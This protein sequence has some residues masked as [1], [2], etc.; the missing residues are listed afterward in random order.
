MLETLAKVGYAGIVIN[1]DGYD[2]YGAAVEAG[3]QPLLGG[4]SI[5][6]EDGRFSFFSLAEY[7]RRGPAKLPPAKIIQL[8]Y[9][10]AVTF[11]QGFFEVEHD[12]VWDFRWC[13]G[14]GQIVIDNDTAW[15]RRVQVGA[16]FMA[17]RPPTTVTMSGDLFSVQFDL[18]APYSLS[19]TVEIAPGRHVMRFT[20][21]GQ[22]AIAPG[23]P[24][25]LTWRIANF[26]LDEVTDPSS[27]K[28]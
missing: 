14:R 3:L 6:S 7:R 1:R 10:L 4:A 24:R 26:A 2:D 19:R 15:T 27:A 17:A 28:R 12:G 11:D 18:G 9:P 8:L 25:T 22:P 5:T 13:Q 21:K 20:S 23:D 16:T